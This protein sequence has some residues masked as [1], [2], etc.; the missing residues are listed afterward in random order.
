[1][2]HHRRWPLESY[3]PLLERWAAAYR[4]SGRLR[5]RLDPGDL[6]QETLVKAL[7]GAAAFRGTTE[8]EWVRWLQGVLASTLADEV[9]RARAHK[10]DVAR[11]RSLEDILESPTCRLEELLAASQPSPDQQAEL[12]ELLGHL[13]RAVVSLPGDQRE[14]VVLCELRQ[15]PVA[16]AAARLSRT[17]KSVACLLYRGRRRLRE[18]LGP[19]YG[20]S[21]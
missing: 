15:L 19:L 20:R 4:L 12:Q 11:E 5:R 3:Y 7:A 21:A 8:A 16:E 1:M 17:R 18:L 2:S 14:A 9:R 13:A 6:V 10:R